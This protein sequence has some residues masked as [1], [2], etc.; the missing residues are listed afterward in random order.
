MAVTLNGINGVDPASAGNVPTGGVPAPGSQAGAADQ[1][2][3]AAA[4]EVSFTSLATR[5]AELERSLTSA[6]PV[7]Q[8]RVQAVSNAL[9][10]GS[11][12]I[13]PTRIAAGLTQ[14]EQL[15]GQLPLQDG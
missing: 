9:A 10:A 13:D 11:Y 3:A 15:L 7:S 4:G 5:M 6:S 1:S 12:R 14:S 8:E 2:A